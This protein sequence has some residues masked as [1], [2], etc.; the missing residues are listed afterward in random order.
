MKKSIL[1][2]SIILIVILCISIAKLF[3]LSGNKILKYSTLNNNQIILAGEWYDTEDSTAGISVRD[4]KLAFFKN[5]VFND[6][7]IYKYSIIDSIHEEGNHKI[8]KGQY[9]MMLGISDDTV[10]KKIIKRNNNVLT[11]KIDSGNKSYIRKG[12]IK[13]FRKT[14]E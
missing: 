2:I 13:H 4:D 14:K 5:F 7:E 12:L 1:L 10:Y 9:L 8:S 11:L 6:S 3:F